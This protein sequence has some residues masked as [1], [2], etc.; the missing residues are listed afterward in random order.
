MHKDVTYSAVTR[1][2]IRVLVHSI[3]SHQYG[4]GRH[5][6]PVHFINTSNAFCSAAKPITRSAENKSVLEYKLNDRLNHFINT[7]N[8]VTIFAVGSERQVI[9]DFENFISIDESRKRGIRSSHKS[10]G[11]VGRSSNVGKVNLQYASK[12]WNNGV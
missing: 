9:S 6:S 11:I 3:H 4:E 8:A 2:M 5:G 1:G 10:E 7:S 12:R